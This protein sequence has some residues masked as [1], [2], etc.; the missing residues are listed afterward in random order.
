MSLLSV[1]FPEKNQD[2]ID[3]ELDKKVC[4]IYQNRVACN[5]EQAKKIFQLTTQQA[6]SPEWHKQRF[7]R[8]TASKAHR[9]AHSKTDA[10]CINYFKERPFTCLAVEYGK[11]MENEAKIKYQ[12]VTSSQLF[13]TG[14]VVSLTLPWLCATPDALAKFGDELVCVEL[15]C[16]Y[17]CS[18]TPHIQVPYLFN[19]KLKKKHPYYAQCQ[20]QMFCCNLKKT[21][22]FVYSRQDFVLVVIDFDE[23]YVQGLIR[24]LKK[25]YFDVLLKTLDA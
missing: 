6:S 24:N 9:I 17:S 22:F 15:K 13:E 3:C 19:G 8:I 14:L 7:P 11:D 4:E 23:K 25:K 2:L 18:T 12:Q 20:I 16:P 5:E 21:H 10:T 1:L